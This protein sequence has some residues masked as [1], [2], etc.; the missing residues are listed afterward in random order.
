MIVPVGTRIEVPSH[1]DDPQGHQ[2][3]LMGIAV[4]PHPSYTSPG[5][6]RDMRTFGDVCVYF[7]D[8]RILHRLNAYTLMDRYWGRYN[9]SP[10][11]PD[12]TAK[13]EMM[14]HAARSAP[15]LLDL[16]QAIE[17][18]RDALIYYQQAVTPL[19][20]KPITVPAGRTFRVV[21]LPCKDDSPF[22]YSNIDVELFVIV[23]RPVKQPD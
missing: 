17:A 1:D 2:W 14:Q 20:D 7:D 12:L 4:V 5:T 8:E 18:A 3:I 22:R 19:F 23:R 6:D 10:E 21:Q 13:L 16:A 11:L 9:L 15:R